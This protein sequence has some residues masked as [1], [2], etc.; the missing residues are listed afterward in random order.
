KMDMPV[1]VV[2]W[3]VFVPERY[4]VRA[5]GG[6]VIDR[7]SF[8]ATMVGS[9]MGGAVTGAAGGVVGEVFES[10]TVTGKSPVVQH[11]EREPQKAAEP[12]AQ[13]VLNLQ[14]RAAGILPVRVDVPRAGVSHQFVKPLVVDQETVVNLKYK[15][16]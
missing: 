9:V 2:D 3:E 11:S 14:Q 4:A 16:R 1:A 12:L 5:V 7:A 8:P 13:N 6:N 10:V 15:R